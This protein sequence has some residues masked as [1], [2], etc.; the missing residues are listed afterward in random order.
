MKMRKFLSIVIAIIM[1]LGM[2]PFASL[3]ALATDE[4]TSSQKNG[5]V[6]ITN[7]S[8]SLTVNKT[9][10]EVGE[11]IMVSGIGSGT[12]WIGIYDT[13][14][15]GSIRYDYITTH[16]SG[17]SFDIRQSILSNGQ[18][19]LST[20]PEGE[21]IIRLMPNNQS[22]H[23]SAK[24]LIKIRVG[25]PSGIIGDSTRL[26]LEKRVFK[27]GEPVMVS[28]VGS[29]TDW[30]G[31]VASGVTQSA[32]YHYVRNVGSGVAYDV[33]QGNTFSPGSYTVALVPNDGAYSTS[34]LIAYTNIIITDDYNYAVEYEDVT[35]PEGGGNEGGGTEGGGNEGGGT[36]GGGTEGG[37]TEG[38]GTEGGG[39]EGGENEGGGTEG[40]G[41]EGGETT[42]VPEGMKLY[43]SQDGQKLILKTEY[44]VNEP[45][46]VYATGVN[47]KDWVGITERGNVDGAIRWQYIDESVGGAGQGQGFDL[48]ESLNVGGAYNGKVL[49]SLP[50]GEYTIHLVQKDGYIKNGASV[51]TVDIT[52]TGE[53]SGETGGETGG[54]D[55]NTGDETET[56]LLKL[57]KTVFKVGEPIMVTAIGSDST[58]WVGI[59][60]TSGNYLEW[61]YVNSSLSGV[62]YDVTEGKSIPAGTYTIR[63]IPKDGAKNTPPLASIEITIVE[64]GIKSPVSATYHIENVG[65]GYA[66]GTVTVTMPKNQLDN[67]SIVMYWA[68]ANGKLSGYTSLAR[69]KVTAEVT[70]FTFT[71]SMVIPNG[72]T[73]LLVYSQITNTGLLSDEYISIDLPSDSDMDEE[74]P[75]NTFFIISDIHIGKSG[76]AENFKKM[77]NEAI[78][79]N[80]NGASIFIVGD[81]ADNGTESQF[82]E[83]MSL[84]AQVMEQAGKD[85]SKYPLFLTLGNHDY[86]SM[87]GTFLSYAT[88]PDGTH[89]TDTSY[90]FWLNGYHYIFLGSDTNSG[91]HAD[92]SEETLAWLDGKLNECRDT[93][94]PTFVFLH[95]PMYNTVAGSLPGEG[96]HGVKNEEALRTVLSK[97][98]EVMFFNG[99]THWTMDSI[100]NIF[101]GTKDLP[102]HIFNC[103]SVSY[104]WSGYNKTTGENLNGSQGYYIEMYDGKVLVRGRDFIKGEW[105]SSAQ[106]SVELSK[107]EGDGHSYYVSE[108]AYPDGY[109]NE[110]VLVYKCSSCN[111]TK[112]EKVEA[113]FTCLGYSFSENGTN[114]IAIGFSLNKEAIEIYENATNST[115][116]YGFFATLKDRIG[117]NDIFDSDGDLA[118]GVICA[119]LTSYSV[120]HLALRIVNIKDYQKD[121]SMAIGVYTETTSDGGTEYSYL[122]ANKPI[123]G[124]KYAF[125]SYNEIV[126][127]KQN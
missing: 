14:G 13:R 43:E 75:I 76:S 105:I 32:K 42:E 22:T 2:V 107:S 4:A 47:L 90:D 28:A 55:D 124:E 73:R 115:L 119:D 87:T 125:I 122:Q 96:W 40:G 127:N 83:M 64:E 98:P 92:L 109:I 91:L 106:Y 88:L 44:D 81:M 68:D 100:G 57:E 11:P 48:R 117:E 19:T 94:R 1:V 58:D 53:N 50:A 33:L 18:A 7:G 9:Q 51:I 108:I 34:E 61:Y 27:V 12:D 35:D 93:S 6:T 59:F 102:I 101:E 110:G 20:I 56:E 97:Y 26:S 69:F 74:T 114:G 89:P 37:G 10:F 79:L 123:D 78:L 54:G 30:V 5:A 116:K 31:I 62:P 63:L 16:G 121:V 39:T 77:L 8:Y 46:Y 120:T 111:Q 60:N 38:G 118:Q 67:R 80:P 103:A 25:N 70:S 86:P 52:I 99:H 112:E 65:S 17:V 3:S 21:Y 24:A 71:D 126:Q 104:L 66:K 82:A 84:H 113:L 15:A 85:G 72:A 45:V 36:E 95:Q 29:G 41:N 23:S 49:A